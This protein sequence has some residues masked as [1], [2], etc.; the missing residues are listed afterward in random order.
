MFAKPKLL[1]ALALTAFIAGWGL[2]DVASLAAIATELVTVQFTSRGWFIMLTVS[3]LLLISFA[4][5][6]SRYGNIKL[7][8]DDDEPEFDVVSWLTM[9]FSA[10]MG[11]GLLYWATAEPVTHFLTLTEQTEESF[12]ADKALFLTNFHWG[13]H[14]WAIYA[15]TGLVIAY[16]GFRKGEPSVIGAPIRHGFGD[17]VLVR[18][19]AWLSDLLA[20]FAIAIGLGGSVAMG[21]FQVQEGLNIMFGLEGSGMTLTVLVFAALCL[22]YFPALVV[23]LGK[24]MS[25]LANLAMGI[26]ILLL[27]F[28][29]LAGPTHYIMGGLVQS[30]GEYL[31]SVVPHGFRTFTFLDETVND[32]FQAW[33]LNYMV[34]WLA[35][36]PF[37]GVFIA[38]ISKGRTIRE[39]LCGVILVPTAFSVIWFGVFGGVGFHAALVDTVPILEVT[40][41]NLDAVTYYVLDMFPLP[42]LTSIAVIIAT[43]L[44]IVTS[45]VSAAF[46]LSMFS[47]E[48]DVNPPSRV[49]LVWGVI[50]GGLGFVMILTGDVATVKT[51]I[52]LGA[53][54]FVFIVC[55]LVVAFLKTLK[56]EESVK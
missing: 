44:F 31:S 22:C 13:L 26:A 53:L 5:A 37:V 28:L 1:I 8:A 21:V 4:I 7:G 11:V 20:I 6:V 15:M 45:V 49:K 32:W 19:V 39:F 3:F 17:H 40:R 2:Y 51:I 55:L 23:D 14:A 30:I 54:P 29:L 47:C 42:T 46:V 16:F 36:A 12:A 41:T 50:L 35:W 56:A 33:T 52:A 34:W 27:V 48:G 10:G 25:L 18:A 43:F 9:L 24:G 38:R